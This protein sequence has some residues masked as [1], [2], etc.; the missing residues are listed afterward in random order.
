MRKPAAGANQQRAGI[1]D[2]RNQQAHIYAIPAS[3]A[4]PSEIYK[5][6]RPRPSIFRAVRAARNRHRGITM[7]SLR[8]LMGAG[9]E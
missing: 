7:P 6:P 9:D 1:L 2:N 5:S 4:S 8:F 3:S